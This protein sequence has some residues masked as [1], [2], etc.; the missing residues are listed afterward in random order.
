MIREKYQFNIPVFIYL[1]LPFLLYFSI[2]ELFFSTH[3]FVISFANP[4][5]ISLVV[6]STLKKAKNEE[7]TEKKNYNILK[8]K[9]YYIKIN[10]RITD[11]T[12]SNEIIVFI[13]GLSTWTFH[14]YF[15]TPTAWKICLLQDIVH[16]LHPQKYISIFEEHFAIRFVFAFTYFSVLRSV[17]SNTQK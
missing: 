16:R 4:I 11:L 5:K 2:S 7:N 12:W 9:I 10:D 13:H 6:S 8:Y 3:C 14:Y 15:Q 1:V 17:D